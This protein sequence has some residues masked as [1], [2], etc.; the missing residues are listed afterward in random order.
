MYHRG[1]KPRP[2]WRAGAACARAWQRSL[3]WAPRLALHLVWHHAWVAVARMAHAGMRGC[4]QALEKS[5][6]AQGLWYVRRGV[7]CAVFARWTQCL[8]SMYQQPDGSP[9]SSM[10]HSTDHPHRQGLC[11]CSNDPQTTTDDTCTT[12]R[13][14][15][16]A[17]AALQR[18]ATRNKRDACVKTVPVSSLFTL[19]RYENRRGLS[20]R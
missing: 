12:R 19:N 15:P 9:L 18:R 13:A 10:S 4:R 7:G 3:A 6:Y 20:R 11:V 17:A 14:I 1:P 8:R 16:P 2:L 5:G